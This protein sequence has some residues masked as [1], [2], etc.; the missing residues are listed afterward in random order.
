M[1]EHTT[2]VTLAASRCVPESFARI[3]GAKAEIASSVVTLDATTPA[4][5][6]GRLFVDYLII[7]NSAAGVTAAETLRAC[8]AHASVLMVSDEP[9]PVYGRPLISY[10]LEGKTDGAHL[11]YKSED[12][13]V[14][15]DIKTLFGPEHKVVKLDPAAHEAACAD[16]SVISYGKCLL[17][18]GSV[19]FVPDIKGMEGRTNVHHFMTL[20]D[21]LGVWEDAIE[22]T[23]RAHAEG[24][25][26]R[27]VVVGGGLIGLK[28]AES[29]SH[30]MDDV[31]VFE[32][33]KRI[34]PAVLDAEGAGMVMRMLLPRGI[35]CYPGVSAEALLGEG[36]R[37][38]HARLTDGDDLPCDL[39]VVAVGV[40]PASALAVEA[41]AEQGRGLMVGT[42]LQTTLPDV[43]AAGDVTQVT[44]RLNGA[45]R[46]LA[47]WPNAVEQGRVAALHMAGAADAPAFVDS[48]AINAVD[49]YDISL[50]T[51]G[52]INPPEEETT[53]M[54]D[55]AQLAGARA[56]GSRTAGAAAHDVSTSVDASAAVASDSAAALFKAYVVE[57]SDTYAKFVVRDDRLVGYVLLNRSEGAGVYTAMI[58]NEV[59]VSTLGPDVFDHVP[60]NLDFPD[61]ARWARL[62]KGYPANR[63]K[64]GWLRETAN[65][66]SE[67]LESPVAPQASE[68]NGALTASRDALA[69]GTSGA[70][71]VFET[72]EISENSGAP[73]PPAVVDSPQASATSSDGSLSSRSDSFRPSSLK[74]GD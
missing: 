70:S 4:A 71:A 33:N 54:K 67:P 69:S 3:A 32:R 37:V 5:C 13:Y 16:G 57:D 27:A 14:S 47:L 49:F 15:R 72:L 31:V 41:G 43:Y 74:E 42:D 19:A 1:T 65:E 20:D 35:E 39:V 8:D 30:H 36:D 38:T 9:Y 23:E 63:Q 18:T 51:S 68:T 66:S 40:R 58:E 2:T 26:S 11:G 56:N 10:L 46:P 28:A 21:A 64:N 55:F 6:E 22:V 7:G 61:E 50:L 59:P 25:E 12:F 29:L 53:L 48:F 52:V 17:A 24:R 44:D 62:H 34:L 45:Q 60:Q 73:E